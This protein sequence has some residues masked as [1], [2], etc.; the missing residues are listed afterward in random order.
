MT[1]Q[2]QDIG[3]AKPHQLPGYEQTL[4]AFHS[5]FKGELRNIVQSVPMHPSLDVGDFGCGDGFY[6][7]LLGERL[8]RHGSLVGIDVNEALLKKAARAQ[9]RWSGEV[10][11]RWVC[12]D[13]TQ[14]ESLAEFRHSFDLL[15]CA[16]S[17]F[18]FPEPVAA[19]REMRKLLR[20]GGLIAIL[21]ND[22]MHQCLLPWPS[23]MELVIRAAQYRALQAESNHPQKF[24]VGRR[25]PFVL[26]EAGFETLMFRTQAVDKR[27]PLSVDIDAFIDGYL[28]DLY[29]RIT[30]FVE[31]DYIDKA[32]TT[33]M[34][35][36]QSAQ[37]TL[38]WLNIL[39]V[40]RIAG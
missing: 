23:D 22:T 10:P 27:P 15:W 28:A 19:L 7:E 18:S 21:E 3:S 25:L 30:P 1:S 5:G 29:E 39:V 37:F 14:P 24:Y 31:A 17:L 2:D 35:L 12:G 9:K 26:E 40:G 11:T 6:T 36:R 13:L 33:L 4:A 34:R 8:N 16:Q 32:R 20:P 38:C